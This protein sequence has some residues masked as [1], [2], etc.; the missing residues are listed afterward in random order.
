MNWLRIAVH[1]GFLYLLYF[2][3]VTIQKT[4]DLFM[5][6]SM[7][8]MLILLLLLSTKVV[9]VKWIEEGTAFLLRHM[10]LVFL[11]VTVG[12]LSFL[13]V[14]SG[15]G[16]LLIVVALISTYMVMIASGWVSQKLA[17]RKERDY[18]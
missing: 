11:P 5:P 18:D 6:G 10:P 3:G 7:I 2:I 9:K 4:F 16:F 13:D 12:I 1:I 17:V 15:K 8:G 14:F